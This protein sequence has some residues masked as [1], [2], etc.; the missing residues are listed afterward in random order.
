MIAKIFAYVSCAIVAAIVVFNTTP[1]MMVDGRFLQTSLSFGV[2]LLVLQIF[3]TWLFLS[4]LHTFSGRL[5]LAYTMFSGGMLLMGLGSL[6]F[7]LLAMGHNLNS[8]WVSSGAATIPFV[9]ASL[10]V[11][12]SMRTFARILSVKFFATSLWRVLATVLAACVFITLIPHLRI[13]GTPALEFQYDAFMALLVWVLGMELFAAIILWRIRTVI[14]PLYS[15]A[16]TWLAIAMSLTVASGVVELL[17]SL[18][19]PYSLTWY[20]KYALNSLPS[21]F[22]VLV[23]LI[24]GSVFKGIAERRLSP[25]AG[26]IDVIV[27]MESLASSP[28]ALDPEMDQLRL[29]TARLT[30]G[31]DKLSDKDINALIKLYLKIEHY[32]ITSEPLRKFNRE[33]LRALLPEHFAIHLQEEKVYIS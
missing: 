28:T 20:T 10:A 13:T 5:R 27:Y 6:Q 2:L 14:G 33:E 29:I 25:S 30:P 15:G 26:Y 18:L 8:W 23:A 4:S 16:V 1:A 3:V 19:S 31:A 21:L 32:L 17:Y 9:I 7:P 24:A 12:F 22:P 11:Y